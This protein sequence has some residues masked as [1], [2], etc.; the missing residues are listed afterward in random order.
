VLERRHRLTSAAGFGAAVRRGR[1]A[2]TRTLVVHLHE[3]AAARS[4]V[5]I[6]LRSGSRVGFVVGKTV[7]NAV[8]RNQ[9]KRRL[10]HLARERLSLLPGSAVLVVR[11]LPASATATYAELGADLDRA[12]AR[13]TSARE[14]PGSAG[15]SGTAAPAGA[16]R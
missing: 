11:A 5:A 16:L 2:G 1:R 14:R 3:P 4:E 13:A 6:D 8:T 7:G 12:L 9:V 15:S 10:R